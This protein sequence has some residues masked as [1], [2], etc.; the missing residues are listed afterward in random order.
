LSFDAVRISLANRDALGTVSFVMIALGSVTAALTVLL[1]GAYGAAGL[2]F[3]A[4]P[5]RSS[6]RDIKRA[7]RLLI[8]SAAA[9]LVLGI[10]TSAV[11][12]YTLQNILQSNA[13]GRAIHDVVTLP[14]STLVRLREQERA[15]QGG[16]IQTTQL[17]Y[18]RSR[19]RSSARPR[20][21]PPAAA[22]DRQQNGAT[23]KWRQDVHCE[24]EP[25]GAVDLSPE[26]ITLKWQTGPIRPVVPSLALA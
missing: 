17:P 4:S 9:S 13:D 7:F 19:R 6:R 1:G 2:K 8:A 16:P 20:A 26:S 3:V 10:C 22:D 24:G 18:R 15:G 5:H 14:R 21:M 23:L 12:A 25:A 11:E